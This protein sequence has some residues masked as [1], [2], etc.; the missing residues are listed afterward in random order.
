MISLSFDLE[1]NYRPLD[2]SENALNKPA[3][4]VTLIGPNG[5]VD[6]LALV[7]TG[8]GGCVFR[9]EFAQIIGI[10][11][12]FTGIRKPMYG[13]G[14]GNI[15][16]YFHRIE[17]RINRSEFEVNVGFTTD[18]ISYNI[19]GE[20]FLEHVQLGVREYHQKLYLSPIP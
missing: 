11:D 15:T 2:G 3:I 10:T 13:L 5:E 9:G 19:L 14:G 12:I 18:P 20:T 7:D 8:A 17:I 1:F 6:T 16:G 4:P